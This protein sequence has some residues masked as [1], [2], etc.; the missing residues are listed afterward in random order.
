MKN[1]ILILLTSI[2]SALILCSCFSDPNKVSQSDSLIN[3][4]KVNYS[5]GEQNYTYSED[6]TVMPVSYNEFQEGAVDF[7]FNLL[8]SSYKA[9]SNTTVSPA[10]AYLQMGLFA[11]AGRK[12]A[13]NEILEELGNKMTV[14]TLN[15]SAQY[16]QT[17]LDYLGDKL[18]ENFALNM[19]NDLWCNDNLTV[20]TEFLKT[21]AK[22]FDIDMYRFLFTEDTA[23]NKINNGTLDY[24]K[25][26]IKPFDK[27]DGN[28]YMYATSIT[29]IKDNWLEDYAERNISK[30]TFKGTNGDTQVS[31]FASSEFYLKDNDSQGFIKS[32]KNTPLK[33]CVLMPNENV[34]I[35]KYVNSLNYEKFYGLIDSI[36][37]V[38][39]CN[40]YLPGFSV[41]A[42]MNITSAL[43]NMGIN[44]V[45]S[46][47]A[48]LSNMT[49]TENVYLNEVVQGID[50]TIND[51]GISS[52]EIADKTTSSA[53]LDND[54]TVKVNRPFV[55]AVIDNES[56]IPIYLGVV[57]NI[58]LRKRNFQEN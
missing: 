31:Y 54:T 57:E 5:E 40:A 11:N 30:D 23:L 15:Q 19:S 20:K 37:A 1:K 9:N 36:D 32:F 51:K 52:T 13:K 24:T 44:T 49:Q 35:E 2:L 45:F 10:S 39:R 55:F 16:F 41:Q 42:S 50:L 18:G 7:S 43:K 17:R 3:D 21:N 12:A 56:N 47:D 46:K 34:S 48:I 53:V 33:L 14:E 4:V 27:I 22:Y 38:K 26:D 6:S 8:K 28:A 58:W 25:A 29:Q